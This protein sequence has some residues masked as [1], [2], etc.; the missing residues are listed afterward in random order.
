MLKNELPPSGS[1]RENRK[2]WWQENS[3]A[4]TDKLR[5][6]MI[7]HC[8]I[9]HDWQFSEQHKQWLQLYYDANLLLMNCMNSGCVVSDEV[10]EE[11]EETLLLPIADIEKRQQQM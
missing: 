9:G 11:I 4:W 10:R 7:E 5:T 8:N 1:S 3:Q 2:Q 6:V